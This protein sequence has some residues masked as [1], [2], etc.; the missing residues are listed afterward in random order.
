MPK[1]EFAEISYTLPVIIDGHVVDYKQITEEVTPLTDS[2]LTLLSFDIRRTVLKRLR[3]GYITPYTREYLGV[4]DELGLSEST[5]QLISFMLDYQERKANA[6]YKVSSLETA[7][8]KYE[9]DKQTLKGKRLKLR[10]NDWALEKPTYLR[11][12]KSAEVLRDDILDCFILEMLQDIEGF[13]LAT[14]EIADIAPN[15]LGQINEFL[16]HVAYSLREKMG[17]ERLTRLHY[18]KNKDEIP[19]T[20]T[21]GVLKQIVTEA[22][23]V[24]QTNTVNY[25]FSLITRN[26]LEAYIKNS[27]ALFN[28]D[29]DI[30]QVRLV[31]DVLFAATITK[32]PQIVVEVT[33]L[34][35][36]FISQ[37][38]VYYRQRSIV[39]ER[40]LKDTKPWII[41]G[42]GSNFERLSKFLDSG[43]NEK[44][45]EETEPTQNQV[46]AEAL[47]MMGKLYE[48][49]GYDSKIIGAKDIRNWERRLNELGAPNLIRFYSGVLD[50]WL[51][52]HD[53][54][55]LN[56][57]LF[58]SPQ[59]YKPIL[60][61]EIEVTKRTL[62]LD[63]K[64][65]LSS[66]NVVTAGEILL[67]AFMKDQD[68]SVL[69]IYKD[70]EKLKKQYGRIRDDYEYFV[71]P[72]G[73][74]YIR[75]KDQELN[76]L[77]I[78]NL[79]FYPVKGSRNL[80][81]A[82]FRINEY[83]TNTPIDLTLFIGEDGKL[84]NQDGTS[85]NMPIFAFNSVCNLLY[86]KLEYITS[87]A[88]FAGQE[89]D[90]GPGGV[91]DSPERE[92]LARRSHWRKLDGNKFSLQSVIAQRH[93]KE[94]KDDYGIDTWEEIL[95][96][97]SKGTLAP[98]QVLTYVKAVLKEGAEPNI[99]VYKPQP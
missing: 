11:E 74:R 16:M 20:Q 8:S 66:K 84:Y 87:G 49:L 68:K 38:D 76:Q 21:L 19:Q 30:H 88:A 23:Q 60:D 17:S 42:E 51:R 82:T 44:F 91:V 4:N 63:D 46:T 32:D 56:A 15:K 47:I 52:F 64:Y 95:S 79:T 22:S 99:I 77:G 48:E 18:L 59:N 2:T 62:K 26:L 6:S 24:H 41:Y 50:D 28:K 96:R 61:K 10:I 39:I 53:T 78:D 14:E 58:L 13:K 83:Y 31:H 36:G 72:N 71:A 94:V 75:L 70:S 55:W 25:N 12:I 54:L 37:K 45:I 33:K 29:R 90:G 3:D 43:D 34:L 27:E 93:I 1:S 89:I 7:N 86:T 69:D 98:N 40:Y 97:R 92:V 80:Y 9:I 81:R 5:V 57:S 35:E 73:D 85:P 67:H 65:N